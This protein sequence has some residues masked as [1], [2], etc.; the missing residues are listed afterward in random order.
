M[1]G[2]RKPAAHTESR[3]RE[4]S[5]TSKLGLVPSNACSSFCAY[6]CPDSA[7]LAASGTTTSPT[8]A[9][10]YAA[11]YS[12]TSP[13]PSIATSQPN[14]TSHS[15]KIS[16]ITRPIRRSPTR[17]T[18]SNVTSIHSSTNAWNDGCFSKPNV[19]VVALGCSITDVVEPNLVAANVASSS[20]D[21]DTTTIPTNNT[22][23]GSR[24]WVGS[25][26]TVEYGVA[27]VAATY[28]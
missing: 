12:T 3:T 28:K 23:T 2:L 9:T 19:T 11:T 18:K 21:R 6:P 27:I 4:T 24:V 22:A 7:Y 5:P 17:T 20:S 13:T 14:P 8:Y 26:S 15:T 25:S 1:G 10:T 16:G